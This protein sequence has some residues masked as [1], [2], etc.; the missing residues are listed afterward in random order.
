MNRPGVGSRAALGQLL[1]HCIPLKWV[2]VPVE[3]ERGPQRTSSILQLW[4][5]DAAVSKEGI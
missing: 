1:L 2:V 3:G 4:G 5:G